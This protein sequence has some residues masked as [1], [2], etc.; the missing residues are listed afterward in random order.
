MCKTCINHQQ[1]LDYTYLRP[2]WPPLWSSGWSPP[3]PGLP[4]PRLPASRLSPDPVWRWGMMKC[5]LFFLLFVLFLFC[6][7]C[8]R[9]GGL[10][11]K[12]ISRPHT[13][14]MFSRIYRDNIFKPRRRRP[15]QLQI[16]YTRKWKTRRIAIPNSGTSKYVCA[17]CC[18]STAA[19][20]RSSCRHFQFVFFKYR[21]N[22]I[23]NTSYEVNNNCVHSNTSNNN[24]QDG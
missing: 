10:V 13:I 6:S 24:V 20:R 18:R 4:R 23:N 17:V 7:C 8:Q 12:Y 22:A 9:M 15:L 1:S 2:W 3:S 19:R 14:Q 21:K 11:V 16:K 5:V